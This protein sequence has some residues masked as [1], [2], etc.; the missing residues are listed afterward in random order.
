MKS[1]EE[2]E[3]RI[4]Y[5]SEFVLAIKNGLKARPH[6]HVPSDG[7]AHTENGM[8]EAKMRIGLYESPK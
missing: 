5:L 6:S 1:G 7:R 2:G 4:F 3:V 8:C